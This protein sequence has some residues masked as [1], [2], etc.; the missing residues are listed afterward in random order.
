[1]HRDRSRDKDHR[2]H[3]RRRSRSRSKDRDR[4][5]PLVGSLRLSLLD[6]EVVIEGAE[7]AADEAQQSQPTHAK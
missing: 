4:P 3:K 1:M 6:P 5:T 2:D 7:T